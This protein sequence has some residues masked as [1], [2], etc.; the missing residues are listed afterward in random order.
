MVMK[1]TRTTSVYMYL[2]TD[3]SSDRRDGSGCRELLQRTLE[4][5]CLSRSRH[6]PFMRFLCYTARVLGWNCL[7]KSKR[8][9]TNDKHI[10][11]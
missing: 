10:I 11:I 1:C 7:P 2:A 3:D 6:M 8:E 5:R 9:K 4:H